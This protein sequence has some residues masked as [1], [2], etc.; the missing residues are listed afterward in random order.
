M[1]AEIVSNQLWCSDYPVRLGPLEVM[2]RMTVVR[3][4]DGA[5]WVHSPAPLTSGLRAELGAIGVVRHV[6]APN[7]SHHLHV[8][9]FMAGFPEAQGYL[10]PG[11]QGRFAAADALQV[12]TP[13]RDPWPGEID[14]TFVAGLPLIGEILFYHRSS[15]SLVATD[16]FA[17]YGPQHPRLH[18]VLAAILGVSGRL[19]TSRT[20]RLAIADPAALARSLTPLRTLPVERVIVG[21]GDPV[22]ENAEASLQVALKSLA[23]RPRL[24]AAFS[25]FLPARPPACCAAD[26]Q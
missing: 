18:R 17:H 12:L 7:N 10:A 20:M 24:L 8:A 5:L 4:R 19:A 13:Q 15:H 9:G 21:H 11:L 2:S 1:L 16:L 14:M 25:R 23:P 26:D 6:V 22:V 3:L